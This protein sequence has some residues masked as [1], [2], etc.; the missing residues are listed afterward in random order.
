MAFPAV[1]TAG[2]GLR[3]DNRRATGK[4]YVSKGRHAYLLGFR[5]LQA[6]ST[7]LQ[8]APTAFDYNTGAHAP[9]N[10]ST[11]SMLQW[12]R[13]ELL[14]LGTSPRKLHTYFSILQL[15]VINFITPLYIFI[16]LYSLRRACSSLSAGNAPGKPRKKQSYSQGSAV[17][18]TLIPK[19]LPMWCHQ[20]PPTSLPIL[21]L[22][23]RNTEKTLQLPPRKRI[24]PAK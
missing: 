13:Y 22:S 3:H 23:V 4:P 7:D 19:N 10:T 12:L 21:R 2:S 20:G 18:K 5:G 6:I 17:K 24:F 1:S 14:P 11:P 8:P 15:A 9:P 16:S